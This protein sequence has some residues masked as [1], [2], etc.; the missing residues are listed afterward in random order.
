MRF[1]VK[2]KRG[3]NHRGITLVEVVVSLGITSFVG[4]VAGIPLL[5]YL[6]MSRRST[7]K[8]VINY[9][10]SDLFYYVTMPSSCEATIRGMP[11]AATSTLAFLRRPLPSGGFENII[12][13]GTPV[14]PLSNLRVTRII[15][16]PMVPTGVNEGMVRID[17]DIQ[18]L[19]E[20]SL[21]K[22]RS[23]VVKVFTTQAGVIDRCSRSAGQDLA[24]FCM[25]LGGFLTPGGDCQNI[26][27]NGNST[28][29]STLVA[30]STLTGLNVST[31]VANIATNI[32]T[33]S[34][35]VA[36]ATL[37]TGAIT[38]MGSLTVG[39]ASVGRLNSTSV[40]CRGGNCRSFVTTNCGSGSYVRQINTNGTAVCQVRPW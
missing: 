13:V 1:L 6:E 12:Q 10:E 39:S 25:A 11:S 14:H 9:L 38:G 17:F 4:M 28:V 37:V 22:T 15:K 31:P 16:Q 26:V 2:K 32:N 23:Y 24:M 33:N 21:S 7:E 27:V 36:G 8:Q 18:S 34:L 29:Q 19:R 30:E 35:N 5:N 3:G 20:P 40:I